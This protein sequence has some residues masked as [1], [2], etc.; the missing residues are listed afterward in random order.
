MSDMNNCSFTGRL[1]ADAVKKVLPTGKDLVEF[2]M[3][4]NFGWGDYAKTL[5][6]TVNMWGKAG[7][8]VHPYLCKGKAVGVTGSIELQKWTSKQDG[9]QQQKLVLSCNQLTL[10]AD[11]KGKTSDDDYGDYEK[12]DMSPG[13][14][15]PS[16]TYVF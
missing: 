13:D 8:A 6:M 4:V 1:T 2:S 12:D 15:S 10:L 5:F 16:A 3:A 14:D 9:S 7:S 11:G